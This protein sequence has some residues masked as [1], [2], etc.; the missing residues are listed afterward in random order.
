MRARDLAEP[1]PTVGLDTDAMEAARMMARE[2]RPGLIVRDERGRPYTVLPGSQ[3]LR[4]VIP[5]YVQDDP[6]LARVYDE[7]ASDELFGRLSGSTVKDVPP[8]PQ[9]VN[10]L[11]VVDPD[12]TTI[13]VAAVMAGMHSPVVAVVDGDEILGAITVSRLLDHVLSTS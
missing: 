2:R 7:K 8:R 5:R 10:E 13:E 4:F 3:V 1:F 12:A 6:A 11:P 9:D